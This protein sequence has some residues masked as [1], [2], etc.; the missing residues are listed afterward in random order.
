[1]SNKKIIRFG[2]LDIQN[3][4]GRGKGYQSKPITKTSSN[5]CLLYH[6]IQESRCIFD[7]ITSNIPKM[8]R[9]YVALI[10]KMLTHSLLVNYLDLHAQ[11]HYQ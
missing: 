9:A 4:Q 5:N 7:G 11:F 1:M 2:F 10:V 6:T 3:N 8:R